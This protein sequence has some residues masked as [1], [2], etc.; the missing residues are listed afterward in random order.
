ML[1]PMIDDASR[2]NVVRELE[3]LED[4]DILSNITTLVKGKCVLDLFS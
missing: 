2:T 1:V 4:E 3:E